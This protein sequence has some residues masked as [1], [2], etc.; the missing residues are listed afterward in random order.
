[1]VMIH[2]EVKL[3]ADI[4]KITKVISKVLEI[5]FI[6]GAIGMVVMGIVCLFVDLPEGT[7]TDRSMINNCGMVI[8]AV[9][10]STDKAAEVLGVGYLFSAVIYAL[11]ALIFRNVFL[12]VK[13]AEGGTWFSKGKTPFQEDN[14][15]MVREIG[16]F[17]IAIFLVGFVATCVVSF[18]A[19]DVETSNNLFMLI[20]GVLAICLSKMFEYGKELQ[21][22]EDGLI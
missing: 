5:V 13:T 8:S 10:L 1:M 3:M 17:S 18:M 11:L 21:E 6:A 19:E 16:I 7:I 4:N 2:S 12:I 9:G 14:V 22:A 20:I 15:R